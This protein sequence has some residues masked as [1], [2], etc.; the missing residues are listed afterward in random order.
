LRR[1][2]FATGYGAL[3]LDLR[4]HGESTHSA[5]SSTAT[6]RAFRKE[7]QDNEWNRMSLD[8][9]AAAK[10]LKERGVELSSVAVAGSALGANV[11]LKWAAV[12]PQ[13]KLAVLLSPSVN[14][15]DVLSVGA[16]R[17]Y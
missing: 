4:G 16:M 15:K 11:A 2:L 3:A 9:D 5:E 1:G 17:A 12:K 14:Y 7:G 8:L 13:V 6:W 10:F